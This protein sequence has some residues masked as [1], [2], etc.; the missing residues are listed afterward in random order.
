M[1]KD[2]DN[3]GDLA[4]RAAARGDFD[5]LMC[6]STSP[7]KQFSIDTARLDASC[8]DPSG[9]VKPELDLMRYE[10]ELEQ[11]RC[12]VLE[13]Q[14]AI[15][16]LRTAIARERETGVAERA[17][18]DGLQKSLADNVVTLSRTHG[19]VGERL[20]HMQQMLDDLTNAKLE[21][22]H[23][24]ST[25]AILGDATT[26][27][28]EALRHH[29]TCLEA[30]RDRLEKMDMSLSERQDNVENMISEENRRIWLAIERH[31]D[32]Q[33]T[34]DASIG[35][36]VQS[37]DAGHQQHASNTGSFTAAA[38]PPLPPAV[39]PVASQPPC[40]SS[41]LP[42]RSL[43]SSAKM[44][45]CGR[46]DTPSKSP[47]HHRASSPPLTAAPRGGASASAAPGGSPGHHGASSTPLIT[48]PRGGL[49]ASAPPGGGG[50]QWQGNSVST[51]PPL[52][53]AIRSP[54]HGGGCGSA[55]PSQILT[56][57]LEPAHTRTHGCSGAV[58]PMC[59]TSP[60]HA[61]TPTHAGSPSPGYD[62]GR[63]P[64]AVRAG[65]PTPAEAPM[66]A[67]PLPTG[68]RSPSRKQ[69]R[70]PQR[71]PPSSVMAPPGS[72]NNRGPASSPLMAA[73]RPAATRS[74]GGTP[75]QAV[76]LQR[77]V[78]PQEHASRPLWAPELGGAPRVR[79]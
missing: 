13:G 7:V 71:P 55:S 25:E 73:Q 2:A 76:S 18:L 53:P 34:I 68:S 46:S 38:S 27:G 20:Q 33:R 59:C 75:N 14:S 72:A 30:L 10:C 66:T 67:S 17:R 56:I 5:E 49:S 16:Q 43:G 51:P 39:V 1:P 19:S 29:H 69:A 65:S 9:Q 40:M 70:T 3:A 8:N 45:P 37:P 15:E 48:A 31:L 79:G 62:P 26:Q 21:N 35:A 54:A 61:V 4:K 63:T 12:M 47:G 41:P 52:P 36:V 32:S 22:H 77:R 60:S 57:D 23:S 28:L 24:S 44:V 64:T 78:S 11:L 6:S 50:S 58:T 74:R 42:P